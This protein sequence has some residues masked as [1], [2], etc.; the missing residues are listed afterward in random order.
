MIL[1]LV[2][3]HDRTWTTKKTTNEERIWMEWTSV[4][5][6]LDRRVTQSRPRIQPVRRWRTMMTAVAPWAW[7]Q[8]DSP[9]ARTS[10]TAVRSWQTAWAPGRQVPAK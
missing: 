3:F 7:G 4:L 5:P 8:V 9:D 6:A 10:D 2:Y 1:P